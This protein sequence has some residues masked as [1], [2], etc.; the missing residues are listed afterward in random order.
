MERGYK[1]SRYEVTECRWVW[2]HGS[3]CPENPSDYPLGGRLP[4]GAPEAG[5]PAIRLCVSPALAALAGDP[6]THHPRPL[7]SQV[8]ACGHSPAAVSW[9]GGAQDR[10]VISVSLSP[11]RMSLSTKRPNK[12]FFYPPN[13][14]LSPK[15]LLL[16]LRTQELSRQHLLL[17]RSCI[18]FLPHPFNI[19]SETFLESS[20]IAPPA[21]TGPSGT[22]SPPAEHASAC[23][24]DTVTVP[25]AVW[26]LPGPWPFSA[27]E[28]EWPLWALPE[29]ARRRSFN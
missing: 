26:L 18:F 4:V 29:A 13:D 20:V 21:H 11:D 15:R 28:V 25:E 1:S 9:G 3:H 23:S 2:A 22:A 6:A 8:L 27:S 5:T 19:R 14:H 24:A 16:N 17:N 7:A 10:W 12:L